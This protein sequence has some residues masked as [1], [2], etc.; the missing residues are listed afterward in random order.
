MNTEERSYQLWT[1]IDALK[2]DMSLTEL[3]GKVGIKYQRMKEQR[4]SGRVPSADDI[5]KISKAL[6][7]TMEY[8]YSGENSNTL[9]P[10]AQFVETNETMRTLVRYCMN[11][12]RLLPALEL[13]IEQSR[14]DKGVDDKGLA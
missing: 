4:S 10:E 12:T 5:Y 6:H 8:I 3:A 14:A 2:G 11:D 13:V 9:S 7:S 1:R